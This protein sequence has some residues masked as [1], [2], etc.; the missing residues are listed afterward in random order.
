MEMSIADE[1]LLDDAMDNPAPAKSCA[2]Y[3]AYAK[4]V[5][6]VAL[7]LVGTSYVALHTAPGLSMTVLEAIPGLKSQ[8][9]VQPKV[10]QS[11][12][13]LCG[14]ECDVAGEKPEDAIAEDE[15]DT[16]AAEP[17]VGETDP[18]L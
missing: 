13:C 3:G 16:A 9:T 7:A 15:S 11:C 2:C 10:G 4:G 14:G 1:K 17:A 5:L 12:G 18:A 6:Y 8:I